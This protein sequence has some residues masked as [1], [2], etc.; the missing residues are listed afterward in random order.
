MEE[1]TREQLQK[2]EHLRNYFREHHC[3]AIAFSGGVDS[4]FLLKIA[5]DVLGNRAVAVTIKSRVFPQR[6]FEEAAAFC[7]GQKIRLLA[8]EI[9]QLEIAGFAENP[10]NRCYL[11]KKEMFEK[12]LKIIREKGM[13]YLVEGSNTDDSGDYRPG[14]QAVAELGIRSPLRDC[15]LTKADIRALS[16]HLRLPTWD[17]PSYAC[18]ASRFAYGETITQEKLN[19]VN[20]AE[21]L[22]LELGFHQMRVR[23]HGTMA[24]IEVE[25]EQFA[26][27]MQDEIRNEIVRK[28][29]S[30]GFAYVSLDLT[31]YRTGSMNEVL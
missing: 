30:Y 2:L 18:L 19:M 21:Q 11:C 5:A 15:H 16:K 23:I 3:V 6:E 24:R 27:L 4:T 29:T 17:K 26:T 14:L 20:R 31:G 22:L 25:P 1:I 8:C 13:Q 28:L 9:E 12:I 10:K 7:E